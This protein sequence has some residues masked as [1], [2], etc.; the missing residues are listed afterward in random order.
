MSFI[1][2]Q[3]FSVVESLIKG[4]KNIDVAQTPWPIT[5][6]QNRSNSFD[7]LGKAKNL[8]GIVLKDWVDEF[9]TYA[10]FFD[11]PQDEAVKRT[12]TFICEDIR[13]FTDSPQTIRK[14]ASARIWQLFN[15]LNRK[16]QRHRRQFSSI[17]LSPKE[18]TSRRLSRKHRPLKYSNCFRLC[19]R[20]TG[21]TD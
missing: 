2:Q 12:L 21:M 19:H 8:Y 11:M 20:S 6:L 4:N 13:P 1:N 14:A 18:N 7:F 3:R 10:N 5:F 9:A 15:D 16:I 17:C